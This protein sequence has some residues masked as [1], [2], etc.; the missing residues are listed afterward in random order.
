M[1]CLF[2]ITG[3]VLMYLFVPLT[4]KIYQKIGRSVKYIN[5]V[6]SINMIV[7]IILTFNHK[8]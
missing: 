4:E 3:F 7:D 8:A 2:T 1:S 5:L 6:F